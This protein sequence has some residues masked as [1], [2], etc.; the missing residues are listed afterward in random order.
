MQNFKRNICAKFQLLA[1]IGSG[2]LLFMVRVWK[3][4]ICELV[5]C[6]F[7]AVT[8]YVGASGVPQEGILEAARLW[9]L[10]ASSKQSRQ[11]LYSPEDLCWFMYSVYTVPDNPAESDLVRRKRAACGKGRR[12]PWSPRTRPLSGGTSPNQ[13]KPAMARSRQF[14]IYQAD[15]LVV[16]GELGPVVSGP[17]LIWAWGCILPFVCILLGPSD[18]WSCS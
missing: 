2:C 4:A 16:V 15:P 18:E 11:G 3:T 10:W 12:P 5:A 7:P 9:G 17:C 1:I 14:H 13:W 8:I 6:V